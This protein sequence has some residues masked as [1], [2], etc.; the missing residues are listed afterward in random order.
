[1][2]RGAELTAFFVA[3]ETRMEPEERKRREAVLETAEYERRRLSASSKM[4]R[5]PCPWC[6]SRTH[7]GGFAALCG[8]CGAPIH[9][10]VG[11]RA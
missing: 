2:I 8:E 11:G 7:A 1:M 9:R 3:D 5:R 10:G 6:G 4:K